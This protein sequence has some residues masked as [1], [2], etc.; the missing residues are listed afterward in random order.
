MGVRRRMV[1][2]GVRGAVMEE[3]GGGDNG[4]RDRGIE[5]G[6][7]RE[8]LERIRVPRLSAAQGSHPALQLIETATTR[9]PQPTLLISGPRALPLAVCRQ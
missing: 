7:E 3:D 1:T 8:R 4:Q 6:G 5:S 2:V 9:G